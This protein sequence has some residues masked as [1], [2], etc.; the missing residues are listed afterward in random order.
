MSLGSRTRDA[1]P[2]LPYEDIRPTV[3]HLHRLSQIGGKYTLDE[4]FEPNWGHIVLSVTP[5]GLATRTLHAGDVL[6][7]VAYELLDNRVVVSASTGRVSLPL[8]PGSVADFYERFLEAVKPLGI[9]PLRT[10]IEPEIPDAPTLDTDRAER[11]YDGEAAR[12]VWSA[13]ASAAGALETWQAPYRGHR[14]PVGVMWGAFDL[15]ATR[16]NGRLRMPPTTMPI[17]Q[18]NGMTEEEVAL[19]LWLGDEQ[20]RAAAFFA[21]I[22]PPPDG[23]D[24]V[25]FGVEG[26]AYDAGAGLIVLPWDA[27]RAT[28]DPQATVVRFAD[29][30][31]QAAVDLGGW[32]ADLVGERHDG[33]YASTNPVFAT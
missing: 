24:T 31:Y 5:R 20:S 21:Y 25:D 2:P 14:P 6:F 32:P 3:D 19:G 28:D 13:F 33:W 16:W 12:R 10:T 26:A 27:V 8:G 30:V 7:T 22:S 1:W 9:G 17:F 4:P 11:P 29:S 15:S 23:L 18:R